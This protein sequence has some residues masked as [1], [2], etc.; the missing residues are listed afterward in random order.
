MYIYFGQ[1]RDEQKRW[2]DLLEQW[3]FVCGGNKNE[4]LSM[5]R[6]FRQKEIDLSNLKL[7]YP[8]Y[9]KW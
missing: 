6:D 1:S 7:S 8:F 9:F 5:S 4:E 2:F 3:V